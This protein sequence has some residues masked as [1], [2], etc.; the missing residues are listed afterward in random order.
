MV[1]NPS[2]PN[3]GLEIDSAIMALNGSFE[4]A[5]YNTGGYRGALTVLGGIVQQTRGPVGHLQR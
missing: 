3:G 2:N 1:V 5:N 4:V